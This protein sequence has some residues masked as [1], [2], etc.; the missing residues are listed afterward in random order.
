MPHQDKSQKFYQQTYEL[1]WNGLF[2]LSVWPSWKILRVHALYD[3][4]WSVWQY[5]F[6]EETLAELQFHALWNQEF[7]ISI[8]FGDQLVT[9]P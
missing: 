8:Y 3:M 1:I 2:I 5:T 6:R 4:T 9:N 7:R